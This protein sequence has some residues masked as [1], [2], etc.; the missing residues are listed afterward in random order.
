MTVSGPI[1]W[2]GLKSTPTWSVLGSFLSMSLLSQP[3]LVSYTV[4]FIGAFYFPGDFLDSVVK[5]VKRQERFCRNVW[6]RW[7]NFGFESISSDFWREKCPP[8]FQSSQYFF[9]AFGN[10]NN[11]SLFSKVNFPQ[12]KHRNLFRMSDADFKNWKPVTRSC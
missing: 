6:L 12:T 2:L 3:L 5:A 11:L 1:T 9:T 4:T 7:S 10:L 8:N